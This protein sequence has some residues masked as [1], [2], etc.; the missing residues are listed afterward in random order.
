MMLPIFLATMV[1]PIALT[2]QSELHVSRHLELQCKPPLNLI[3]HN[4]AD[5]EPS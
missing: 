1:L 2:T 5:L 4:A 3:V